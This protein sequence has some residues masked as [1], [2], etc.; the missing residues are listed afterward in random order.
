MTAPALMFTE[1]IA[2]SSVMFHQVPSFKLPL[3]FRTVEVCMTH[4]RFDVMAM[5]V[6]QPFKL[7]MANRTSVI[8]KFYISYQLTVGVA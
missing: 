8:R 3:T 1:S 5:D 2:T 4:M 7:F 6:W